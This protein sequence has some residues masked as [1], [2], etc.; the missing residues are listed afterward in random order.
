MTRIDVTFS[1]ELDLLVKAAIDAGV[2]KG[3]SDAARTV[4]RAHF[5]ENTEE[6]DQIIEYLINSNQIDLADAVRLSTYSPSELDA[7]IDMRDR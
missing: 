1:Q 4:L 5:Q 7:K 3:T 6:R 2:F